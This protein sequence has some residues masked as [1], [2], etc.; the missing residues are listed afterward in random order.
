MLQHIRLLVV[1][2]R[3]LDALLPE[4]RH[5]VLVDVDDVNALQHLGVASLEFRDEHGSHLVETQ[6]HDVALLA[7]LFI[8]FFLMMR[9]AR[10]VAHDALTTMEQFVV[11]AN[12][13]GR[14]DSK[15]RESPD[16]HGHRL[17]VHVAE[18]LAKTT[19]HERKLT[20]L[21]KV[22][23]GDH[24]EAAASSKDFDNCENAQP[25]EDQHNESHQDALPDGLEG[26]R[27]DLHAQTCKEKRDEK[28]ADELDL[29]VELGA[30][31][32]R[33]QCHASNERRKFHGEPDKG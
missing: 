20:D 16:D 9:L 30:V 23:C 8:L 24:G 7:F 28:V 15:E 1:A 10:P 27:W 6:K 5:D 12:E 19:D 2:V 14:R 21:R 17:R 11:V 18:A 13:V 4:L 3:A 25:S 22:D 26:G 33:G 31:R 32:E 29:A